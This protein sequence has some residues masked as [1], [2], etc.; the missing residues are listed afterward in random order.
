MTQEIASIHH[1]FVL[2]VTL[3]LCALIGFSITQPHYYQLLT[4]TSRFFNL[5]NVISG[6]LA[7][8]FLTL[9]A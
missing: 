5:N 2:M 7:K 3:S 4:L 9:L 6:P 1:V 8:I